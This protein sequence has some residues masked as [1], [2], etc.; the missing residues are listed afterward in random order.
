MLRKCEM[1][2]SI[3]LKIFKFPRKFP[4][5]FSTTLWQIRYSCRIPKKGKG[6][7]ENEKTRAGTR[8]RNLDLRRVTPYPLGHTGKRAFIS[9]NWVPMAKK[10]LSI[11]KFP[12]CLREF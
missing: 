9:K 7:K 8:T 1:Q 2:V 12:C 6:K 10:F 5:K 4:P 3:T 11:N